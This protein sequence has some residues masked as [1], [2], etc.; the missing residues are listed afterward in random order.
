[1]SSEKSFEDESTEQREEGLTSLF[2]CQGNLE[3]TCEMPQ[4]KTRFSQSEASN[5]SDTC[6]RDLMDISGFI[7]RLADVVILEYIRYISKV[8]GCF[9]CVFAA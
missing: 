6:S 8:F 1:M 3:L 9:L 4:K 5:E 7:Q 2:V